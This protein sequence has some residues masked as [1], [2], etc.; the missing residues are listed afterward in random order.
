MCEFYEWAKSQRL[1]RD[2][3]AEHLL[4]LLKTVLVVSGGVLRPRVFF[5]TAR[6]KIDRILSRAY[7]IREL[8]GRDTANPSF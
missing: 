1:L 5:R 7:K 3:V 4:D 6:L 8:C 2:C